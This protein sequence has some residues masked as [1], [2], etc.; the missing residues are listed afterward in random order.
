MHQQQ[1]PFIRLRVLVEFD[2]TYRVYVARCL[3]TGSVAT[4]DDLETA[5]QMMLELL[6]D[7]VAF[8]FEHQTVANLYSTP[9][10]LDVWKRWYEVVQKQ[11][12]PTLHQSKIDT[13]PLSLT[14]PEVP[15][16]IQIASAA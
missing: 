4:A 9:A 1:I 12:G 11:G 14:E 10:P 8:A 16:E 2:S 5:G 15:T 7:E 6:D 13:K 3:E